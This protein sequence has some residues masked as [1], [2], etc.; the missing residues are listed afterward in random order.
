MSDAVPASAI[1]L[2]LRNERRL[3]VR[4][5]AVAP[6]PARQTQTA[7]AARERR[8]SAPPGS[9][10][11]PAPADTAADR[12]PESRRSDAGSLEDARARLATLDTQQVRGCVKCGLHEQRT[13]TVFGVGHPQPEIVFV[14]EGPGADED[15]Q[16]VPFVGRAGQL[17][18]RMIAAMTLTR[19][20]VYICNVVKCRPPGN[21][22]PVEAEMAA[23][24]PYLFEQLRILRPRLIIAL[25][26][27]ASQTLLS[28]T[29]SLGSLRGR[30]HDFPP[31]G[32]LSEDLPAAKLLATYHPA[33]LLRT[34]GDKG[35]AWE[36]L[37]TGMRY[38]NLPIPLG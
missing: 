2:W 37:K 6:R 32:L 4:H 10:A 7:A 12:R 34:P 36:D 14:G 19:D 28:T 13:Q 29:A 1:R 8:T 33:Y 24:S 22:T 17:L 26:R 9:R 20:Q 18:T 23:C 21:R 15:R 27:P 3:G 16:G 38:L 5:C 25:G 11:A 35:K 31:T 30:L